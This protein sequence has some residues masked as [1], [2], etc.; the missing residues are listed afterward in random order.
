VETKNG[1]CSSLIFKPNKKSVLI[2]L[3]RNITNTDLLILDDL[4]WH[5]ISTGNLSWPRGRF[6]AQVWVDN[7]KQVW[8]YGGKSVVRSN[9]SNVK[10]YLHDMWMF[11][12]KSQHWFEIARQNSSKQPKFSKGFS[13]F[14]HGQAFVFGQQIEEKFP[15]LW[16]YSISSMFWHLVP[17][18]IKNTENCFA[19]WC[20]LDSDISLLC[21]E[22]AV[23][24]LWILKITSG[25]WSSKTLPDSLKFTDISHRNVSKLSHF[26][27]WNIP[28]GSNVYMWSFPSFGK[29]SLLLSVVHGDIAISK[30]S[31]TKLEYLSNREGFIRWVSS[32]GNL[33][34]LGGRMSNV[35]TNSSHW[36][37]NVSDHTWG[38]VNSRD[39]NK[40]S[41]RV[42]ACFWQVDGNL[43]LFGGYR[44]DGNERVVVLNDFWIGNS[45][46]PMVHQRTAVNH[47]LPGDTLGLSLT[48][49]LIISVITLLVVMAVS[50][51]LCYKRELN[52][53]LS[54]L[55]KNRVLY[56][57]VS[58]EGDKSTRL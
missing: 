41:S 50:V 51:R 14:C 38:M 29:P 26:S 48:N 39:L 54:R 5:E 53:L 36:M 11:N 17:H 52:R 3:Q 56:H 57:Q 42:G 45:S 28:Y 25:N 33:H 27:I 1:I 40:P 44:R 9:G 18:S 31:N 19:M 4:N 8:L 23:M 15:K 24:K 35:T 13:C 47:T 46:K 12:P 30:V 55:Q 32:D 21:Y 43:W 58:Q 6:D 7:Q 22:N 37:L 2:K 20:N 49:K 16:A 10:Q 34:L